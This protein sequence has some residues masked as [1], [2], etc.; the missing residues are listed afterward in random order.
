MKADLDTT[1]ENLPKDL[2]LSADLKVFT[3][4]P[5]QKPEVPAPTQVQMENFYSELSKCKI[6]PVVLSLIP[7]YADSYVLPSH[8][9]PIIMDL[10]DKN[11]LELQFNELLKI[12]QSI[13]IEILFFKITEEQSDHVQKDTIAKSSGTNVFKLRT[14]RIGT[15]QSKAAA[16]SDPAL[17]SQSLIQRICYP[18][19][20]KINTKGAS[21]RPQ[22]SGL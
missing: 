9:I 5:V 8:K 6:N 10:F 21:M 14:G 18:E 20:H 7:P 11:N 19:L 13:N 3:E 2:Q 1:I 4:S 22:Q 12:C 15:S 16:H 17:P